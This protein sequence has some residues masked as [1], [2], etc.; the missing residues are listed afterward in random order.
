M[1]SRDEGKPMEGRTVMKGRSTEKEEQKVGKTVTVPVCSMWG[2][3]RSR[4]P[5]PRFTLP[6]AVPVL[7]HAAADFPFPR[8][9]LAL[10]PTAKVALLLGAEAPFVSESPMR[11]QL[12]QLL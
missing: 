1:R 2:S 3:E 11:T 6:P 8:S 7:S 12:H 5:R 9:R 4:F 10:F